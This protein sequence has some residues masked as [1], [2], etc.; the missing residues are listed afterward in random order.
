MPT[1]DY[2]CEA[3]ETAFERYLPMAEYNAPQTCEKCG[4][5]AKK[6]I[7]TVS[8]VLAGDAWPGK[9]NKIKNQMAAKNKRLDKKQAEQKRDRPGMT[10]APNVNGERVDSWS[11]AK[12]LAE[13]KGLNTASY[14]PK[15]RQEAKKD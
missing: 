1:Y 12:K 15:V 10:L 4:A 5:T 9:A 11:D 8:F 3:C 6:V 2:E 13:S 7:S 14:D